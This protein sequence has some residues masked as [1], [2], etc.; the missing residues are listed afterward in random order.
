MKSFI[1]LS[2]ITLISVFLLSA[3]DKKQMAINDLSDFVEK[4]DKNAPTFTEKD[5]D[6]VDAKYDIIIAE[7]DKYQFTGEEKKQIAELK[8]RFTGIK[9]KYS[10]NKVI[11]G[12]GDA[13]KEIRGTIEGFKDGIVGKKESPKEKEQ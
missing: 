3:C 10:V 12:V 2:I 13:V 6:E 11:E 4:V 5:W 7:I 8:G 9:T 1:K